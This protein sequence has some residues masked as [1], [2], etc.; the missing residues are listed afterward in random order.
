MQRLL[1]FLI[2]ALLLILPALASPGVADHGSRW[3]TA[4]LT[5]VASDGR[6][7]TASLLIRWDADLEAFRGE[8]HLAD[9]ASFLLHEF[10]TAM[11]HVHATPVEGQDGLRT[12]HIVK[13]ARYRWDLD[14]TATYAQ[15]APHAIVVEGA[16]EGFGALVLA[17]HH[18]LRRA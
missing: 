14:L 2:G 16:F 7:V 3:Q 17:G 11:A 12:L 8:M 10:R 15:D 18:E 13:D 9:P 1:I 4:V 6:H 5:G